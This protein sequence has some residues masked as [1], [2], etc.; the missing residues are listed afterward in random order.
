[1]S[2]ARA[3]AHPN[4][5][6][7][8][9]VH[10]DR[11]RR[12]RSETPCVLAQA[13][14]MRNCAVSVEKRPPTSPASTTSRALPPLPANSGYVVSLSRRACLRAIPFTSCALGRGAPSRRMGLTSVVSSAN[15]APL[16]SGSPST[17]TSSLLL[18]N[19]PPTPKSKSRRKTFMRAAAVSRR[20]PLRPRIPATEH[21]ERWWPKLSRRRAICGATRHGMVAGRFDK[22]DQW[23]TL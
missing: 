3:A 1:M 8:L 15:W 9:R 12:K 21:A 2:D 5:A 11:A 4:M 7:H 14:S 16:N 23:E 10:A 17:T 18:S 22:N 13:R 20:H 6:L 19:T